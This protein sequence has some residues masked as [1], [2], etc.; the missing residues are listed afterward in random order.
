[1]TVCIVYVHVNLFAYMWELNYSYEHT[2]HACMHAHEYITLQIKLSWAD[3]P[4]SSLSK[5]LLY[6]TVQTNLCPIG[7]S[8]VNLK[9]A[10]DRVDFRRVCDTE[11]L[12]TAVTV[13]SSL[14]FPVNCNIGA[15]S[16]TGEVSTITHGDIMTLLNGLCEYDGLCSERKLL[17]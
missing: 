6:Y 2:I 14:Y 5:W 17:L 8:S 12:N 16:T 10:T 15:P 7:L 13:L 1:M 4:S 11:G 3:T 9:S